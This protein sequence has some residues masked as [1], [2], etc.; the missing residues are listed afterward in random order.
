MSHGRRRVRT[1]VG[2]ECGD[3]PSYA[4]N[5]EWVRAGVDDFHDPEIVD[6]LDGPVIGNASARWCNGAGRLHVYVPEVV[7]MSP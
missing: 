5:P 3:E 6:L 7:I 4:T 1:E 2:E